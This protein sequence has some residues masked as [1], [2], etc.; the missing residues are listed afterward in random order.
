[1]AFGVAGIKY[2][3]VTTTTA[4]AKRKINIVSTRGESGTAT[5]HCRYIVPTARNIY[6]TFDKMKTTYG[7]DA[8]TANA[9]VNSW[10]TVRRNR[11]LKGAMMS[12]MT[13]KHTEGGGNQRDSLSLQKGYMDVRFMFG[14][15][16]TNS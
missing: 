1:M 11:Q 16:S 7:N 2:C 5:E 12:P 3:K 8:N 10:R 9:K 14:T 15:K 4:K 6:I 13:T